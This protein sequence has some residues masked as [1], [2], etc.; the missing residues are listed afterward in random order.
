[1]IFESLSFVISFSRHALC[2]MSTAFIH[3]ISTVFVMIHNKSLL[4]PLSPR[5]DPIVLAV[6]SGLVDRPGDLDTTKVLI[7]EIRECGGRQV[8]VSWSLA[9]T[10]PI[11]D[12]DCG[13]L[14]SIYVGQTSV[15]A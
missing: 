13:G 2:N 5:V 3:S 10:A 12:L 14:V 9:A 4:L 8:Q 15:R 6:R 1:M 7:G 11:D